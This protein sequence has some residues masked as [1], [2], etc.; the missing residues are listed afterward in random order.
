M[1]AHAL[2]KLEFDRIRG[3]LEAC[4]RCA[5]GRQLAARIEP[6]SSAVQINRWL[7]QT[8]QMIDAVADVGPPPFGGVYDVRQL[9][10][11]ALNPTPLDP[12]EIA[13]VAETLAATSRL[14][15]WIDD[16]G[17]VYALIKTL[18]ERV[19]D[20]GPIAKQIATAIDPDG[21]VRDD[22]S[23]KLLKIRIAISQAQQHVHTV[24]QRLLKSSEVT[25]WLQ[26]GGTTFHNERTVLPLKAEHRGRIQGIIHRSSDTGATLFV[27][28]AEAV[29]LNN[30]LVKLK[31]DEHEEIN[32]ILWKLSQEIHANAP[33]ITKTL[34]AL[35]VIDL[36]TAKAV[37]AKD[38]D[39]SCPNIAERAIDLRNARHPLLLELQ[40]QD[41]KNGHAPRP[42]VPIDIRLG[43]DFDLLV[44]TG[45]NTG[46]KT[47][48]LKTLGLLTLM[49]Q[50][51]LPIPVDPGST[52]CVVDKIMI[53]VGD[54][55]SLQQSL[56]TFS[57]HITQI[58]HMISAATPKTLLL[59]DELGSGTDPDE[60]AAIGQVIMEEFLRIGC[61]AA[62]TTHIGVLKAVAFTNARVDNA[63]V[64]FDVK[65]MKPTYRLRIGEPGNSNALAIA[66]K[67]G[68]PKRLVQA[69]E[70]HMTDQHKAL[71]RAIA[72]TLESRRKSETARTEAVQAKADA[73]QQK[74]AFEQRSHQLEQQRD[75]FQNWMK[76]IT[77]LKPGDKVHLPKFDREGTIVRVRLDKQWA[78][79]GVGAVEMEVPLTD[80]QPLPS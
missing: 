28:P 34:S 72:G 66:Q 14:S 26:Y 37:F 76:S 58:L 36:T 67:L 10:H 11:Q 5:L 40:K 8:R 63:C 51:G 15:R 80:L 12:Q 27:E 20:F 22:A 35:G 3:L 23:K 18:G 41:Q 59:V 65:T 73:E 69:A 60:G 24:F 45:P 54:E 74:H 16:L 43:D 64:D 75:A 30:T 78:L 62:V 38:Y 77:S 48:T 52:F 13:Q 44:I 32:R 2:E 55:Q 9:V 7:D 33:E 57:S 71:S 17:P 47:A 61:L 68:L 42:V 4:C 31:Q 49:A 25:R 53:D 6:T 19:G 29:E 46:G 21:Q 50:S 79:V 1:D 70:K 39:L 56:S